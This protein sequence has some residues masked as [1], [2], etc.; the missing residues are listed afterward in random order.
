MKIKIDVL[1]L[2]IIFNFVGQLAFSQNYFPF[3]KDSSFWSQREY[4]NDGTGI[5]ENIHTINFEGDSLINGYSYNKLYSSGTENIYNQFGGLISST[6][7]NRHLY[8]LLREDSSKHI[9]EYSSGQEQLIY[10][11]NLELN[12]TLDYTAYRYILAEGTYVSVVDSILIGTE[13][14][15]RFHLSV[16]NLATDYIALIEGVGSSFGLLNFTGPSFEQ[17]KVLNCF[18]NADGEIIFDSSYCSYV[19]VPKIDFSEFISIFPNPSSQSIFVET[20]GIIIE[21]ISVLDIYGN[22]QNY[23]NEFNNGN[24]IYISDLNSGIYFLEIK[25]DSGK[26]IKKFVKE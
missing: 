10:D 24:Q 5:I 14:H 7:V 26:L 4:Y 20:K 21:K 16:V 25:T 18:R 19:S 17:Y 15:K 11:F 2:F 1:I 23:T 22:Q 6:P 12:D 3:P 8:T 9:F 13:Y